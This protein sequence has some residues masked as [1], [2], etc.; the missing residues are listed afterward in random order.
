ML[1][2]VSGT[3]RPVEQVYLKCI[4]CQAKLILALTYLR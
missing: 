2:L 4:T 1:Q 3:L